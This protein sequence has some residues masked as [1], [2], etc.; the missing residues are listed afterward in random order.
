[1]CHIAAGKVTNGI[2]RNIT[3]FDANLYADATFV[4]SEMQSEGITEVSRRRLQFKLDARKKHVYLS[5]SD[6]CSA[7][8]RR[9]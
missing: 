9:S 4:I 6:F 1:M 2:H 3:K 5:N 8:Q 7:G